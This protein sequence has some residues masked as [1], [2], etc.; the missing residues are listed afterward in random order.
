MKHV[1]FG[2]EALNFEHREN[3]EDMEKWL[4]II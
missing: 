3:N 4:F 1:R 2:G